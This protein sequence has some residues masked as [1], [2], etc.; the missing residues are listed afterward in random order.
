MIKLL[1]FF[2]FLIIRP[3]KATCRHCRIEVTTFVM[4]EMHPLFPLSALI[5]M[6][7]FGYLS[8]I[9][10]PVV[11]LI[12]QNSVH[13]CSRC[14]QTLGVKKCFGLPDDPSQPFWHIKLG[15]CAILISR[16][17]AILILV[18]FGAFSAYYVYSRPF[19]V[20]HRFFERPQA[21]SRNLTNTWADYLTSCSGEKIIENQVHALHEFTQI[22]ENNVVDW[23]GYYIDTKYKHR[24]YSVF[25]S[26]YFMSILIKMDPSESEDFADL[27]LSISQDAYKANK[28]VLDGLEKGDHLV[29]KARLRTMGNEFKL[30]HLKLLEGDG[31]TK[32]LKDSGHTKDL[33]HIKVQDTRIP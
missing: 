28:E 18:A 12:S 29:F 33:E 10:C 32:T 24:T 16:V 14:L 21:E 7:I 4:H 22:Y 1:I 8:L 26:E 27:V 30:H 9:I 13:R 17:Y 15:K 2:L 19:Q 31:D 11:Y 5:I 3:V 23:D 20:H 6:F 25:G